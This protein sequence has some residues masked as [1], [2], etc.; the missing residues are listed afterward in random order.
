MQIRHLRNKEIDFE[1]W[2][3][4]ISQSSNHLTYAY[5]WYLDAMSPGWEALVSENY[6]YIMPL[7][8]KR[9]YGFKILSQPVLTQQLGIFSKNILAEEIVGRFIKHIPYLSYRLNLNENNFYKKSVSNPNSVLNLTESYED[10]FSGYSKNT[11]RNIEKAR[12]LNLR[13]K[14]ELS[15]NDFFSF[16]HSVERP[17][18][19]PQENKVKILIEKAISKN[20]MTIYGVYSSNEKLAAALCLLHSGNRLTYLLPISNGEGKSNFAMFFLIDSIIH[21]NGGKSKILD[22]E[23]SRIQ[24]IARFYK[25]FGAKNHPYFTIKR[26]RPNFRKTK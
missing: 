15:P 24:G 6:E 14:T 5:S 12:K 2:D 10:I 25:G 17:F 18:S 22:F 26:F 11:Q 20:A 21:E 1:L 23:G 3:K 8:V 19:L 16:F 13:I 7:P 4:C 9:K